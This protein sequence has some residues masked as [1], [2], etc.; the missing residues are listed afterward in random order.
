MLHLI[1]ERLASRVKGLTADFCVLLV[2]NPAPTRRLAVFSQPIAAAAK[3]LWWRQAHSNLDQAG[4]DAV[5]ICRRQARMLDGFGGTA[6]TRTNPDF[7]ATGTNHPFTMPMKPAVLST[8]SFTPQ[9]P[10]YH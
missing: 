1:S 4:P 7:A 6:L 9:V 5:T 3:R 8:K 10:L 2:T